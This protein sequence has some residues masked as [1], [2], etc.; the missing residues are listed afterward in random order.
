MTFVSCISHR[1]ENFA[2][3]ATRDNID[4]LYLTL[5]NAFHSQYGA[6]CSEPNRDK[7]RLVFF[8]F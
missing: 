3:L 6:N 4:C 2:D 7:A 5:G 8:F 1:H